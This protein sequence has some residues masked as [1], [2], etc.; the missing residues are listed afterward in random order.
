MTT[1]KLV[2]SKLDRF[3]PWLLI[4]AGVIGLLA[5]FTLTME[6]FALLE[7]PNHQLACDIN[8]VVACG[9]VI[10][11]PQ[12]SAFNFPNPFIG[13]A[14]FSAMIVVGV[15]LLAGMNIVKKWYWRTFLLG[16]FL[17]VIFVH[18]LAFQSIYVIEALCPYCMVVWVVTIS[19]FWYSLVWMLR[20]GFVSLPTGWGRVN[21]FIQRNHLGILLSWFLII[22]GLILNHFWYFFGF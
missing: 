11:T 10:A 3:Y 2:R 6:K 12:A 22:I 8:P 7:N 14:A 21:D 9:S 17:G 20:K 5:A 19:S 16:T 1:K 18:W 15:S 13:L 4:I